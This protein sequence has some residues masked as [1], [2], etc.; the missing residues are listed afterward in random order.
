MDQSGDK[1]L[2]VF[3]VESFKEEEAVP[4]SVEFNVQGEL[5][6]SQLVAPLTLKK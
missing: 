5:H 2:A 4:D 6:R 3:K 1:L